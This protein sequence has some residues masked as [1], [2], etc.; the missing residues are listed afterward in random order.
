M[1][2][3]MLIP[4]L[5]LLMPQAF[6]ARYIVMMKDQLPVFGNSP[7]FERDIDGTIESRLLQINSYIIHSDSEAD[8]ERLKQNPDVGY[9]EKDQIIPYQMEVPLY[10]DKSKG[11]SPVVEAPVAGIPWG[12]GAIHAQAAWPASEQGQ[13]AR[14]LLI[15]SGL[16]KNHPYLKDSFEKGRDFTGESD[17]SD[18]TDIR[19]HGTHVAGIISGKQDVNGFSGVAPKAKI[20]M[21]RAC[22][23]KGCSTAAIV[24]AINW[25]VSQKVDVMNISISGISSTPAQDE[26]I[27]RADKAGVSVVAS[28]GNWGSNRVFFP[29]ALP[30]VIAVGAVDPRL[31]RA[32]FSQYGPELSVVAPGVD[33]YS[34][35]PLSRGKSYSVLFDF[36]NGS[37][38]KF[39]AST[40][41][42]TREVRGSL[43]GELVDCGEGDTPGDFARKNIKGGFALVRRGS[44][45]FMNK[46]NNAIKAGAA[47]I[48]FV[49][50]RPGL[51]VGRFT[52]EGK[53]LPISIFMIEKKN[54]TAIQER[55]SRGERVLATLQAGT[56]GFQVM[57]GTSMAAP[58]VTGVVALMKAANKKLKSTEIKK[59]LMRTASAPAGENS[60]NEY[61]AGLLNAENAVRA[62]TGIRWMSEPGIMAHSDSF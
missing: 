41:G 20:L 3:L 2:N 14:V 16:D 27:K 52:E 11:K 7:S 38:V 17:G 48:I 49:N 18:I 24:S 31:V 43:K 61:G 42:G 9:V 59:I 44:G 58:H 39:L 56:T 15:D 47:A 37:S 40:F 45:K 46:I 35:F 23:E 26:A 62:A 25:G 30:T 55:V 34:T 10:L 21:A 36:L 54:A 50:N 5:I 13:G 29:A 4:L 33:V 12:V 28:S 57:S 19:G 53:T 8:F 6:A 32:T 1:K 51:E 60:K 22:F